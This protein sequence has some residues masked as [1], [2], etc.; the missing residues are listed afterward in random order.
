MVLEVKNWLDWWYDDSFNNDLKTYEKLLLDVRTDEEFQ[1]RRLLS[2]D[3]TFDSHVPCRRF[4]TVVHI[5]LH[6]L[7]HRRFELPPRRNPFA[8]L[9]SIDEPDSSLAL[10][11][12]IQD[13]LSGRCDTPLGSC[14]SIIISESCKMKNRNRLVQSWHVTALLNANDMQLWRSAEQCG[15]SVFV[16]GSEDPIINSV[17]DKVQIFQPLPR[18]W[19]PDPMVEDILLPLI[20][21]TM[22]SHPDAFLEIWD[23]GSGVGRDACF[24]AEELLY[25]CK[26]SVFVDE[27]DFRFRVI[28]WDQ[29][30]RGSHTNDIVDF[31][32][33]R[34]VDAVAMSQC[35]DFCRVF[36]AKALIDE[37]SM[38]SWGP[39]YRRQMYCI[40]MVRYWN[41][42]LLQSLVQAGYDG[43]LPK[44]TICAISHFGK[45]S[46]DATWDFPHPKEQNVLS[47]F[48]LREVFC[49]SCT[50]SSTT[51]GS[52]WTILHDEVVFDSDHGRTIIQFA[53]QLE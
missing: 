24:L 6:E 29:R 28:G 5:P 34:R 52:S 20:Q 31:L 27:H 3:R 16:A 45:S 42:S 2:E 32:K 30:Y 36:S 7:K 50:L 10:Q 41:K 14:Q 22:Q 49:N 25:W 26:R 46:I 8:I 1:N 11:Q 33:R 44:G 21:Q 53:A 4:L 38:L 39:N 18:L 48:E 47:R 9:S 17:N 40:Y 23:C 43:I 15:V 51:C 35:V 37:L 13:L 12:R 19:S